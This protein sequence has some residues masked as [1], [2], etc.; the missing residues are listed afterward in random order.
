MVSSLAV[1]AYQQI[2]STRPVSL[3]VL[4]FQLSHGVT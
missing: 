2:S 3:A 1:H 4:T